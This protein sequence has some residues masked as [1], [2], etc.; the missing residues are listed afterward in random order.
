MQD[1]VQNRKD[2]P[3]GTSLEKQEQ[4]PAHL[5]RIRNLLGQWTEPILL[6]YGTYARAPEQAALEKLLKLCCEAGR[7]ITHASGAAIAAFSG[8]EYIYR[9]NAGEVA[10]PIGA[11][12]ASDS[13]FP[14]ACLKS[15]QAFLS[16]RVSTDPRVNPAL[17]Q[18]GIKSL[19]AVPMVESG[20][21]LGFVVVFSRAE[22]LFAVRHVVS[23]QFIATLLA[24]VLS[25]LRRAER[26][27]V[28]LAPRQ[29]A[30]A[31]PPVKKESEPPNCNAPLKAAPPTKVESA[32]IVDH[33]AS[34][35]APAAEITRTEPAQSA[36]LTNSAARSVTATAEP[37]KASESL[38]EAAAGTV[39]PPTERRSRPRTLVDCLAYVSL[40]EENG[41]ILLDINDAG[42][43][44]QTA[45]PLGPAAARQPRARFTGNG[46]LEA[47]CE[48][49]WEQ[50][51]QA[52]FR[53]LNLSAEM[54]SKLQLWIA[55]NAIA[56]SPTVGTVP[57]LERAQAA[58]SVLAKLDELRSMLLNSKLTKAAGTK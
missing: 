15:R 54:R 33:V 19:I 43:C 4:L 38:P 13:G 16:N 37:P 41:G 11:R 51:G 39:P 8:A 1:N 21:A 36:P 58:A 26:T 6:D 27:G 46:D 25:D 24:G 48:L 49:V 34:V 5:Q 32:T 40:G 12:V 22:N 9:M 7:Q 10:P 2:S 55:A 18:R 30:P 35:Q 23:L 53:F 29:S 52:G 56:P 28:I 50:A 20:E 42:F 44:M 14:G 47:D 57:Q 31:E 3:L 17:R 45:L